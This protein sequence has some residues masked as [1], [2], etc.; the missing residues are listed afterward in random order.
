MHAINSFNFRNWV[1]V[2]VV[3]ACLSVVSDC[4]MVKKVRVMEC[5]IL[6]GSDWPMCHC[7]M[8][9]GPLL[10]HQMGP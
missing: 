2:A 1:A 10:G 4:S 6:A 5:W 3:H 9:H 8:A 7:A